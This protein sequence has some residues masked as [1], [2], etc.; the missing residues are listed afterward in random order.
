MNLI[1]MLPFMDP[2]SIIEYVTY[3]F[4]NDMFIYVT[5]LLKFLPHV[6][7]YIYIYIWKDSTSNGFCIFIYLMTAITGVL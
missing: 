2:H 4:M 1:I 3:F 5:L 7:V 6:E